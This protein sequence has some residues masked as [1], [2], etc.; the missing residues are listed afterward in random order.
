[1]A[2]VIIFI[3][4][5]GT[6][7][8]GFQHLRKPENPKRFEIIYTLSSDS[9]YDKSVMKVG[10]IDSLMTEL[11]SISNEIQTKQIETIEKEEDKGIFDKFYSII[12][13]V[14]LVFA[15]FFG[16]KNITEIK[17]RA[18]EIAEESS[19]KIAEKTSISASEKQ[20][21]KVF[22]Q[23]YKGEVMNLATDSFSTVIDQEVTRLY[24][25]ITS[26]E[27]RIDVLEGKQHNNVFGDND[28]QADQENTHDNNGPLN[29]F[30]NE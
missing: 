16:F 8:L 20:F 18:I 21:E 11:K 13:A 22:T 2:A 4:V 10:N 25:Q 17:Q 15:G 5:V 19:K 6:M 27:A 7:F 1:M 26:L 9:I 29:P 24:N 3:A 14:V 12:V 28:E 23:Q 30:D